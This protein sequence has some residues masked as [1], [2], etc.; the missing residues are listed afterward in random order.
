MIMRRSR[1]GEYER[2]KFIYTHVTVANVTSL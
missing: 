2:E 1:E